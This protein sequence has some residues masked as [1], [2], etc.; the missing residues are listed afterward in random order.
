LTNSLLWE[1]NEY[2]LSVV[3]EDKLQI[4][5]S[6]LIDASAK[7]LEE[8]KEIY[9][10]I[11][12]QVF[13]EDQE[14]AFNDM[15]STDIPIIVESYYAQKSAKLESELKVEQG[16]R[17]AAENIKKLTEKEKIEY[18]KMKAKKAAKKRATL[19]KMR[20]LKSKPKKKK[21]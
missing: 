9:R 3:N 14:N 18:E 21:K 5:F 4:I 12:T 20:G 7:N 17:A 11:V 19:S 13:G 8:E 6:P 2:G 15:K 1:L 10:N 16:R